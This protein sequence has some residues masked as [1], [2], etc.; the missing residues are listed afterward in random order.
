[1]T[2]FYQPLSGLTYTEE[3]LESRT[4]FS[5]DDDPGFIAANGIY[6]ITPSPDPYDP[7]LYASTPAY[8]IVGNSAEQSWVASPL[9]LDTA[10]ENGSNEVKA[11]ASGSTAEIL[12]QNN[13]D[14]SV[15]TAVA[16]QLQVDR[17]VPLQAILAEL[18]TVTDNLGS[19]LA[20]IGAAT[21]VD[22]IN[23]IVNKPTGIINIG[24][25]GQP[26]GALM[27]NASYYVSFTSSSLTEADTE[28]YVPYSST[29]I[30]Y[31]STPGGFASTGNVFDFGDYRTQIRI[32]ATSEIIAEFDCPDAPSNE[33]VPF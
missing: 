12:V 7:L 2:E 3:D 29:V 22:E 18:Q 30:S 28:L 10:K 25:G 4:G 15:M 17:P 16:G 19:Q 23:N 24:R 20:A 26:E 11:S 33:D 27:L 13:V 14:A 21:T 6:T 32:V 9:P 8:T 1:M 31:G 5:P